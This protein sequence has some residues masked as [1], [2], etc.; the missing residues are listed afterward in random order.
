MA[1]MMMLTCLGYLSAVIERYLNVSFDIPDEICGLL[2]S[3]YTISYF[4]ASLLEPKVSK[5]LKSEGR[6]VCLGTIISSLSF[7]LISQFLLTSWQIVLL[8]L[9]FTG[10]GNAFMISKTYLVPTIARILKSANSDYGYPKSEKLVDTVSSLTLFFSNSGEIIG[11]FLASFL[12]KTIGYHS[13]FLIMSSIL[14][15]F[16][17]FYLKFTD[18]LEK[19]QLIYDQIEI[20][21]LSLREEKENNFKETINYSSSK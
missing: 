7:I 18:V 12:V 10:I 19:N 15:I 17:F 2:F 1:Q 8:G 20:V 11:P 9:S 16:F 4:S 5:L 6:V 21:D 13:G 14:I 3:I